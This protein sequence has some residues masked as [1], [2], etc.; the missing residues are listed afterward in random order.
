MLTRAQGLG[1]RDLCL[2]YTLNEARKLPGASRLRRGPPPRLGKAPN[3]FKLRVFERILTI[4]IPRIK[5]KITTTNNC[6]NTDT[7]VKIAIIMRVVRMRFRAQ[8]LH[9]QIWTLRSIIVVFRK[10]A[11]RPCG[12]TLAISQASISSSRS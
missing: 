9:S 7:I 2:G 6:S 1:F 5:T 12:M 10:Y 3:F 4:M 8:G 11:K